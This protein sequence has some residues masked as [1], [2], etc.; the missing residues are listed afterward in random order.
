[1]ATEPIVYSASKL[2]EYKTNAKKLMDT[3]LQKV[4]DEYF[5]INE[6]NKSYKSVLVTTMGS[7]T[8][9]AFF[10]NKLNPMQL[11]SNSRSGL[12]SNIFQFI[13]KSQCCV[14]YSWF[15]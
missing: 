9:G 13:K 5:G 6:D 8:T 10:P 12:A 15:N 11:V 1:M 4:V 14:I 2:L 3:K 7:G